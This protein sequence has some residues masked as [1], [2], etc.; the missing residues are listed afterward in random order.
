MEMQ[1]VN[2]AGFNCELSPELLLL[3]LGVLVRLCVRPFVLGL[4]LSFMCMYKRGTK[5][6]GICLF[7]VKILLSILSDAAAAQQW[8]R[9]DDGRGWRGN[10]A[11]G[12]VA[13]RPM[14][15]ATATEVISRRFGGLISS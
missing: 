13:A 10:R 4:T 9:R 15:Q 14:T 1:Q 3:G 7:K 5:E 8:E 12:D 11:T 6:K 2:G